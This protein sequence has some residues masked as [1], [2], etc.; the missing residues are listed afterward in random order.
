M[1]FEQHI[2]TLFACVQTML[3]DQQ[4]AVSFY[5]LE[6]PTCDATS[7]QGAGAGD[8]GEGEEGGKQKEKGGAVPLGG[9]SFEEDGGGRQSYGADLIVFSEKNIINPSVTRPNKR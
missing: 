7:D 1:G 5:L 4:I 9:F 8:G 3:P 6:R 2:A